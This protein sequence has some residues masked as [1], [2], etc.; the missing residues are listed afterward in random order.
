MLK[1]TSYDNIAS[2]P[3]FLFLY[4][5]SQNKNKTL[6]QQQQT[7][8][9]SLRVVAK[10]YSGT[11]TKKEAGRCFKQRTTGMILALFKMV[12]FLGGGRMVTW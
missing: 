4:L 7:T 6:K 10:R 9:M 1:K 11:R 12:T 5:N 2:L 8:A 3:S